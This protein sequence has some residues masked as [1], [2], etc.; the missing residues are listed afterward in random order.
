MK[1]EFLKIYTE[2]I[3]RPGADKFLKWLENSD[4]FIAPASTQFHLS[5]PEGL[6]T[7]S[8]NVYKRLKMLCEA[9]AAY[10]QNGFEQPSDESI[11]ICGLLHDICKVNFYTVE[12]RNRKNEFGQW[13]QVPFYKV[14]D[15]LP[16]GHGEKSV[17]IISSYMKLSR[18]ESFAVRWHMGFGDASATGNNAY[19]VSNAFNQFPLATL[20]HIADMQATYLDE[21]EIED[22]N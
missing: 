15:K 22:D 6:V 5:K 3:T 17:Y 1:E 12:M 19:S 10:S 7:H 11:A 8:L 18:D 16:Y 13:E 20:T 21:R 2:N 14:K 9:E 4:F